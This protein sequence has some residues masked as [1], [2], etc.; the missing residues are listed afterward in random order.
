MSNYGFI[1]TRHVNSVE[2]NKYW[3]QCV[4]LIRTFYPLRKI[5]I[6]DDNSNQELVHSDFEYKNL[7]IIQSEYPGRGELL[8]YFYYLKY[9]WFPNAV[10]IHDSLFIH[11]RISF[12][13]F[14]MPVIP[15]WHHN[16]DKENIDNILR[17]SSSL[18]HNHNLIKKINGSEINIL[19]FNNDKFNLCFGGQAYIKLSFLEHLQQKYN[20]TNLVNVVHNR[21]D[22]C[23]L[24]RV[25]GLLFC[26]EYPNLLKMNSLFGDILIQK[27]AFD[28]NYIQYESDLK[29]G[30][31]LHPFV[32]VWTGR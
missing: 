22:R 8:P 4:K 23:S 28:Y 11:Q 9:K 26:Q 10:I 5:V 18:K 24:E 20:I 15:L 31:V 19:G 29:H 1:I 3:N 16:Y 2:T 25:F 12:E 14:N 27:R 7:T 13:T 21:T 6:I 17:I 32:K 30:K